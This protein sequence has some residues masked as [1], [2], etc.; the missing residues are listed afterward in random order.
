MGSEWLTFIIMRRRRGRHIR[1]DRV[2]Q[3][4]STS[5][6]QDCTLVSGDA[7]M[8]PLSLQKVSTLGKSVLLLLVVGFPFSIRERPLNPSVRASNRPP[9]G[10]HKRS[11]C[12]IITDVRNAPRVGS[13]PNPT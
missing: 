6:L 9:H 4:T 7:K 3:S 11:R 13:G 12:I 2:N 10:P 1:R 8:G 5:P